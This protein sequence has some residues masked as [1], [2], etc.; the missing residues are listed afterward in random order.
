MHRHIIASLLFVAT[1][2][3]Y[4][5]ALGEGAIYFAQLVNSNNAD[6]KLPLI[7][8]L[9]LFGLFMCG[10][11]FGL[12]VARGKVEQSGIR[13]ILLIASGLMLAYS[14]QKLLN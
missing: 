12:Y 10:G 9:G 8:F 5:G 13:L 6:L 7:D 4:A 14:M 1:G 3:A 11:L 2:I